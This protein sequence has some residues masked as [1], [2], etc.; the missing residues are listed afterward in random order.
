MAWPARGPGPQATVLS[1]DALPLPGRAERT[2]IQYR[3]NNRV[4]DWHLADQRLDFDQPGGIDDTL[5]CSFGKSGRF[6]QDLPFCG[7]FRIINIHLQKKTVELRLRQGIGAFLFQRVLGCQNMEWL[8]QVI[9]LTSDCHMIFLH[10][11]QQ[12]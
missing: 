11:L 8:W 7:P 9:S 4:S 12:R 5:R 2:Q 3:F 6:Q 10:R 1:V